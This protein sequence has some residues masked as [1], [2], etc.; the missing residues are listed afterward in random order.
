MVAM[1]DAITRASPAVANTVAKVMG[2]EGGHV[3]G[4]KVVPC[5]TSS[6]FD[7][8]AGLYKSLSVDDLRAFWR[9]AYETAEHA[10]TSFS[11]ITFHKMPPID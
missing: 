6:F 8:N 4:L 7:A 5:G 11:V 10:F 1:R 2:G 9:A 3:I